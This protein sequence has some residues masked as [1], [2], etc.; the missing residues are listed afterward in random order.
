MGVVLLVCFAV[1]FLQLTTSRS[2]KRQPLT[3]TR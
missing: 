2:A 3:E 1:L